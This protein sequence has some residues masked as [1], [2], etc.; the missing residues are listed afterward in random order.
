MS[1]RRPAIRLR[2]PAMPGRVA[3]AYVGVLAGVLLVV[4]VFLPWYA[5]NLGPPFSAVSASGWD[6]TIVARLALAAGALV[7]VA[8]AALAMEERGALRLSIQQGDALARGVVAVGALATLLIG[9]RFVWMPDPA[10]FLSR[11]IGLYLAGAAAIGATLAGL[12][13]VATRE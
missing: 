13:Q 5:T 6:A 3:P 4:S 8:S 12:A 9:V 2:G 7:L 11:Q 1:T 10:E